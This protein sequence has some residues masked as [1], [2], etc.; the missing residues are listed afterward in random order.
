MPKDAAR[1]GKDDQGASAGPLRR[2]DSGI[3]LADVDKMRDELKAA[4]ANPSSS[5]T[6]RPDTGSTPDF[7]PD[8]LSQ[9]GCR[10]RLGQDARVVQALGRRLIR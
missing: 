2:K 9:A 1:T 6:P 10:G 3:P 7:R 5:S 4:A 8:K